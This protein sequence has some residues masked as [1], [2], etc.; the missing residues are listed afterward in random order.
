[1]AM[2]TIAEKLQDIKNI[3]LGKLVEEQLE[4]MILAGDIAPGERINESML[5]SQLNISR[6]PIREACR[7]LAQYG[8]VKNVVGKGTYVC[9][10]EKS[11]AV[12]L[13]E[14]R[15]M[16]DSLAAEKAAK[17]GNLQAIARIQSLVNQMRELVKTEQLAEYFLVNLQ[18]HQAILSAA[19]SETL[20]NMYN[21]VFKKL[22]L[23]RQKNLSKQDRI[24]ISLSQ[25]EEI[26]N[27]IK[28]GDSQLAGR[29]SR[30]HV[31]EAKQVLI[32]QG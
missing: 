26:F 4:N 22:S 29:L 21:V 25:H 31:E 9:L 23:F 18:F 6:A 27:A 19:E 8:M 3:S 11:E 2:P 14:I 15:G 10:V 16:L 1:M 7:Q 5:S 30:E 24:K 17:N 32:E 13:Y 20:S 28:S 12:E